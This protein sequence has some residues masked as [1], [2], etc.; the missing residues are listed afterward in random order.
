[1]QLYQTI[2]LVLT[3]QEA[4]DF[5]LEVLEVEAYLQASPDQGNT[6]TG[7]AVIRQLRDQLAARG[8]GTYQQ[9]PQQQPQ[10]NPT[11][12]VVQAVQGH[13]QQPPQ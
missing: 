8:L 4:R 10:Q 9:Q 5:G 3:E 12:P 13:W 1:M 2:T 11:G 7:L 6:R